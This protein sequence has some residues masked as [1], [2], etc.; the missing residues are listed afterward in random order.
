MDRTDELIKQNI[1]DEIARDHRV[2]ASRISVEVRS[3][4]VTLRG[5]VPT[6]FSRSSAYQ[7]AR[8]VLGVRIVRNRLVVKHPSTIALP[9]ELQ[10]ENSIRD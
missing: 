4:S 7:V 6:H 1:V 9:R 3:G 8:G 5:G 10:I 2:D